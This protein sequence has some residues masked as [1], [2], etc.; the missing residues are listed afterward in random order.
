[1]SIERREKV[2]RSE[3]CLEKLT[4]SQEIALIE[5]FRRGFY[6]K[7][8]RKVNNNNLVIASK[9]NCCI[10]IASDGHINYKPRIDIR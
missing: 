3:Y 7:F 10:T 5:V 6:L 1:M 8:T 2:E 4:I 9:G